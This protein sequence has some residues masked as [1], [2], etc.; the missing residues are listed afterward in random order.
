MRNEAETRAELIDPALNAAGWHVVEDSRIR[1]EFPITLGRL[2]GKNKRGKPLTA[3]YVLEYSKMPHLPVSHPESG[4]ICGKD[5]C[6]NPGLVWL[7]LD[8]E[9]LYRGGQRV[10]GIHTKT[11]KVQ[12]Q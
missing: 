8:E 9:N 11:A 2:E 3:D 1:R 10:F 5:E 12:V 4:L 7:K 6:E